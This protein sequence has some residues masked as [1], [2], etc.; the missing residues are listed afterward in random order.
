MYQ[1]FEVEGAHFHLAL[2]ATQ[3]KN[4]ARTRPEHDQN[5][6]R[7]R[8]SC[9]MRLTLQHMLVYTVLLFG[10][11]EGSTVTV[12]TTRKQA[13]ECWSKTN[14]NRQNKGKY[15][16][17]QLYGRGTSLKSALE[18]LSQNIRAAL[19]ESNLD[20]KGHATLLRESWCE[21]FEDKQENIK[22]RDVVASEVAD[23]VAE[24]LQLLDVVGV[25][26]KAPHS[27]PQDPGF[28]AMSST[29]G[30]PPVTRRSL[31][32]R[33]AKPRIPR[34]S[35]SRGDVERRSGGAQD[36]ADDKVDEVESQYYYRSSQDGAHDKDGAHDRARAWQ[37][38]GK[39]TTR[40]FRSHSA[41]IRAAAIVPQW[42]ADRLQDV[43][44]PQCRAKRR[45]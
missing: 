30:G 14:L 22:L 18:E 5:I 13:I 45:P 35:P 43:R 6:P 37:E 16:G 20:S 1:T 8:S 15:T 42:H 24:I 28:P 38:H 41:Q 26:A 27:P 19:L 33:E 40:N 2:A 23:V 9:V 44:R 4:M 39:N 34:R 25:V 10:V 29:E 3:G 17:R 7:T 32:L 31:V 12:C 11:V 21:E 36:G